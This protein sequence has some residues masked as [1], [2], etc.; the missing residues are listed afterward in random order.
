[1][2]GA[3][4]MTIA[5][6][7]G[8]AV[9]QTSAPVNAE[10]Q[11]AQVTSGRVQT[12]AGWPGDDLTG[13]AVMIRTGAGDG[14]TIVSVRVR[15]LEPHKTYPVHVHN[16][17][18]SF[19]PPGGGHYQHIVAG[20]VDAVNEMWPTIS[21]NAQGNGTGFATHDHR[22]R[23]EAQAIIVHNPSNTSIR[24]ACIDLL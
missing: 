5:V 7:A 23:P 18:C 10:G 15:G 21:T 3:V 6:T 12:L 24:L 16:Q 22:A 2:L 4:A 9:S 20:P 11:G 1:M 8:A 19:T 14:R 13:G 17:P